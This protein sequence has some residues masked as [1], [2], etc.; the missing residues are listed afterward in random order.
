MKNFDLTS[1]D[2]DRFGLFVKEELFYYEGKNLNMRN[3]AHCFGTPKLSKYL[4][5]LIEKYG[6][7]DQNRVAKTIYES[8]LYTTVVFLFI[9]QLLPDKIMNMLEGKTFVPVEYDGRVIDLILLDKDLAEDKTYVESFITISYTQKV[10]KST[11]CTRKEAIKKMSR[12]VWIPE[13]VQR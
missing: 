2:E 13:Q 12:I 3:F 1:V 8:L 7:A 5:H 10:W 6:S 4:E 11:I 9:K